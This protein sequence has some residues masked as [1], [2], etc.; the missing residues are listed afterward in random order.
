MKIL[1]TGGAGH[2]GSYLIKKLPSE[3]EI[4]VID[5]LSSE[6][7]CSFF[8][9]DRKITFKKKN[10]VEMTCDDLKGVDAVLHLASVTNA[11]KSFDKSTQDHLANDLSSTIHLLD[12]MEKAQVDK[13]IFPS[14]TSIY[15]RANDP[16][17]EDD[18]GAQNPQSPYAETKLKIEKLIAKKMLDSSLQYLILRFGTIFGTSAGMRFHTA[19]NK[20]C[21]QA[22]SGIPITVWRQNWKHFRPYLGLNDACKALQLFLT[23]RLDD[24]GAWNQTYNVLSCNERLVDVVEIIKQHVPST[25]IDFVDTPLLNQH[26]YHVSNQKLKD[27][28]FHESDELKEYIA[29]T[30][31]MLSGLENNLHDDDLKIAL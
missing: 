20:F 18:E 14:T 25:K 1:L 28:G 27:L 19:V 30:L 23:E 17:Y 13:F 6:R 4:V 11:A 2:I 8:N 5:N 3:W 7:Y 15:G 24:K 29:K 22:S 16:V 10:V 26:S 9:L 31:L 21:W 12:I